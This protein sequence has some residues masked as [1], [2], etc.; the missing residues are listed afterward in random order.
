MRFSIIFLVIQCVS[1]S[2]AGA[3]KIIDSSGRNV[4]VPDLVQ[5]VICAGAGCLRLLTY[6]E[7]QK[8][9]LNKAMRYADSVLLLK[10]GKIFNHLKTSRVTEKMIEAVYGLPVEIHNIN[11]HPTVVPKNSNQNAY[12]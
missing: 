7:G 2:V 9:D 4:V 11:G 10:D 6:L 12:C 1:T 3:R 5:R 8:N